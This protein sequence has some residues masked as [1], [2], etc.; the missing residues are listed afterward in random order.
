MDIVY[1]H[2]KNQK[3]MEKATALL[4]NWKRPKNLEKV[5]QSLRSQ[6]VPVEIFLWNN[7][8]E[9]TTQYD[10][11]LQINSSRNLMCWPRWF[12]ANYAQTEYVFSLDDDVYLSDTNVVSDCIDYVKKTQ[13][14][15]GYSGVILDLARGY[16]ESKHIYHP[17]RST[18]IEVDIIKW[19]FMFHHISF[20][21][22]LKMFPH[23]DIQK[24]GPRIED[25]I[26]LS[27]ILGKKIIPSF[28]RDRLQ[29]L[30]SMDSLFDQTDHRDSRQHAVDYYFGEMHTFTN[31]PI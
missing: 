21:D 19:R 18:D 3:Y 29:E 11:D 7:N 25:D 13:A 30:E 26:I 16:W 23:R 14:S 17:K 31:K 22:A 5:I 15:I 24:Y 27:S 6:S 28:L 2:S 12:L 9:D 4:L 8:Q 10:V 20:L 1:A